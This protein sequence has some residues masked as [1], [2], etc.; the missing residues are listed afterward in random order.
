MTDLATTQ[1][2]RDY[3]NNSLSTSEETLSLADDDD[4]LEVLD[5]MQILRLVMELEGKYAIKFDNGELTPDNLGS[6]RKLTEF[7]NSKR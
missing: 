6:I 3:I 1:S 5:S 4:L 2:L 7:V